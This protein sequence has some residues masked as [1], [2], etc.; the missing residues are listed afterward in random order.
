MWTCPSNFEGLA[1]SLYGFKR[2]KEKKEKEKGFLESARGYEFMIHFM[3][4]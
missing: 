4:F 2:K 1:Y 3:R